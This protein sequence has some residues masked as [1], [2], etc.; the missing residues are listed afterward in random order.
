MKLSTEILDKLKSNI[1]ELLIEKDRDLSNK[2]TMYC[3]SSG[4]LITVRDKDSLLK[5]IQFFHELDFDYTVLGF[6]SNQILPENSDKPFIKLDFSIDKSYLEE[7][8]ESYILPAS[9]ALNQLTGMAIKFGFKG[10]E[11]F[12]G[13][14][15]S[16]GGAVYMNAGTSLGEIGNVIKRVSYISKSG[17][18]FDHFVSKESFS[19]RKNHF[20]QEGDIIYEVELKH[21]GVD[22]QIGPKIRDYLKLRSNTQPLTSKTCGCI[23]KNYHLD[24]DESCHVGK[25]I[26]I[27]GLK[28][29]NLNQ[30]RVSP[31]HGN[32]FEN[33][34]NGQKKDVVNLIEI[35]K[36]ELELQYGIV[37]ETE[38]KL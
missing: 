6:G 17:A 30:I 32:F 34:G 4:D 23:F 18:L 21:N 33:S 20:L 10:W 2:S 15:A 9:F 31:V 26:D 22:D 8:R 27:M 19:Y 37:F 11:V 1:P 36:K 35:V 38:V 13:I 5:L 7:K 28:G 24:G 29:L 14:P 16:L 3:L 12:T 25:F